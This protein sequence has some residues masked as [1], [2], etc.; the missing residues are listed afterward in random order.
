MKIILALIGALSFLT[1][2]AGAADAN[3][4]EEGKQGSF[5]GCNCLLGNSVMPRLTAFC[6]LSVRYA[7]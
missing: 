2:N 5:F 7:G 1:V 4:M 6:Q 3:Q